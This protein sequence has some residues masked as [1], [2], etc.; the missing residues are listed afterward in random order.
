MDAIDQVLTRLARIE[1]LDRRHDAAALL[2]ELRQLVGE[3]EAWA[4]LEGDR[5]AR[6]AIKDLRC[7]V[8]QSTPDA[9]DDLVG[10][11]PHPDARSVAPSGR[12]ATEGRVDSPDR[13]ET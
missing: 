7:S 12:D 4:R 10:E 9:L 11:R 1:A 3:A 13:A 5:R 2:G 8:G 6:D